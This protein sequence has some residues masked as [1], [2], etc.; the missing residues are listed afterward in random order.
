[1]ND[2]K[3]LIF[4]I[5]GFPNI[6]PHTLFFRPAP[7]QIIL[8]SIWDN[9]GARSE[10]DCGVALGGPKGWDSRGIGYIEFFSLGGRAFPT[11]TISNRISQ[12]KQPI[13]IT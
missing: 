10:G 11:K 2:A 5:F 3:N 8:G 4:M 1:M 6:C 9:F 13:N 7:G 12:A